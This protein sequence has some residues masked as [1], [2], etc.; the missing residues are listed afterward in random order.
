[1]TALDKDTYT[2]PI[3]SESEN[4]L[5]YH[6]MENPSNQVSDLEELKEYI[7]VTRIGRYRNKKQSAIYNPAP[8]FFFSFFSLFSFICYSSLESSGSSFLITVIAIRITTARISEMALPKFQF[9]T[10]INWFS[11]RFPINIY[12]PPP[13]SFGITNVD[14]DNKNVII[15]PFTT[16]GMDNLNT[17]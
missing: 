6:C 17:T 11:I 8:I 16:P 9:P 14:T 15:T 12:C 3:I 10:E 2:A 1:M 5:S 7:M 13:R 4:S